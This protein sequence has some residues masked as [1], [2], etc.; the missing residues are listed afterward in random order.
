MIF[1][2][3]CTYS[4]TWISDYI[5]ARCQSFVNMAVHSLPLSGI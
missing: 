3:F 4:M 5:S 1:H 2:V